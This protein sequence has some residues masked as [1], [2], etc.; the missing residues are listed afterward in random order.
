MILYNQQEAACYFFLKSWNMTWA[1]HS[2]KSHTSCHYNWHMNKSCISPVKSK[3]IKE[4]EHEEITEY[5]TQSV[6]R[7]IS[8]TRVACCCSSSCLLVFSFFLSSVIWQKSWQRG[9]K[10]CLCQG[11]QGI[12]RMGGREVEKGKESVC[13]D[14]AKR[15]RGE[16]I[17]SFFCPH[18]P[19]M[20]CLLVSWFYQTSAPP[21]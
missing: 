9:N 16:A 20:R 14:G 11:M 15:G 6:S 12:E 4:W 7:L 1:I 8:L 18:P 13:V 2:F 17:S 3:M 21:N 10:R 19:L 5:S